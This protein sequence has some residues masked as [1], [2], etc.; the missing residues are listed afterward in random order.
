MWTFRLAVDVGDKGVDA[1][2]SVQQGLWP[3]NLAST[4]LAANILS[5]EVNG[6]EPCRRLPITKRVVQQPPP[7]STQA[8]RRREHE[9]GPPPCLKHIK[10]REGGGAPLEERKG[11][12]KKK[13][14][15]GSPAKALSLQHPRRDGGTRRIK[16][17]NAKGQHTAIRTRPPRTLRQP[18]KS[19]LHACHPISDESKPEEACLGSKA[20]PFIDFNR[21]KSASNVFPPL[22]EALDLEVERTSLV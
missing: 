21:S 2:L 1:N 16:D 13:E 10:G 18:D 22:G 6:Q 7:R 3:E 11:K 8:P 4:S 15:K 9:H 19:Y 12:R 17:L 20:V 5:Q 14:K